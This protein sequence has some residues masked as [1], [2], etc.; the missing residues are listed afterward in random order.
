[1]KKR[2]KSFKTL[3]GLVQYV[4]NTFRN[5]HALNYKHLGKWEHIS[6][7]EF[8]GTIRRLS[9]GLKAI[10]LESGDKCGIIVPPSPQWMIIDLAI[11]V[12]GAVSVPMFPNIS[13]DNFNFEVSDSSMKI[14]FIKNQY[15]LDKAIQNKLNGFKKVIALDVET[16]GDNV[17]NYLEMLYRGDEVSS[18]SPELYHMLCSDVQEDDLATIIYTSGSTGVP[19]G[20]PLTHKNL[21]SQ[22]YGGTERFPLD[23]SKDRILSCLPLAHV[24]ERMV[25]YYYLSTGTS[26]YFADDVKKVG[27]LL[28][29]LHPT[30]ITLVPRLL[31]KVYEKMH[32]NLSG[33][34]G[35]KKA[36]ATL[37]FHH[38]DTIMP[39]KKSVVSGIFNR[40]VYKKLRNALGGKLRLAICGSAKLN[41]DLERFFL[42][43]GLPLYQGYG[44]TEC[45]PVV[46]ANFPEKNRHGT[47]GLPFPDVKVRMHD[48]GE[49]LVKGPGVFRGYYHNPKET[50]AVIDDEGWFH[51]GDLGLLDDDGY[52]TI[53]GRKKE[54]FKTSNGKYVSPV[55]IEQMAKQNELVDMAAVIAEGKKFAGLLLFPDFEN[56]TNYQKELGLADMSEEE[57]LSSPEVTREM[58]KLLKRINAKLNHWE[59][60]RQYKVIGEPIS[61][62]TGELT[63][64]MKLRRHV[65]EK[66]FKKTIDDMYNGH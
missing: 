55:P 22:V 50:K 11:M 33:V 18:S 48:D 10:G 65:I 6:T 21:V 31:E 25:T 2:E 3:P 66:K 16:Q 64:T 30:V 41:P 63:P 23:P 53:N 5:S 26:I 60:I 59:Q 39:G 1:M 61:V 47:V 24:F 56:L 17:I 32:K 52:L 36:L 14:L 43:I 8:V 57:F 4:L 37:A 13:I 49:I 54:L 35:L 40:L 45:S 20:V 51:T 58:K 42:N 9:L 7:E 62:E 12:N 27:E 15:I 44:L 28:R 19:K 46:S 38:A 34:K 29:E